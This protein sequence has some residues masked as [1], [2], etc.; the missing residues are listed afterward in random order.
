MHTRLGLYVSASTA[1]KSD[2]D[3]RP[4]VEAW[5][6]VAVSFRH[7]CAAPPP[8]RDHHGRTLCHE[9]GAVPSTFMRT[10]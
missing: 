7:M 6:A 8:P 9:C 4:M 1:D 2:F 10:H 5:E 3:M